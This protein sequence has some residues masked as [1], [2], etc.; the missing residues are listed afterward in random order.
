MDCCRSGS[1]LQLPFQWQGSEKT[2]GKGG[3]SLPSSGWFCAADV[4]LFGGCTNDL[5]VDSRKYSAKTGALTAAFCGILKANPY[6]SYLELMRGLSQQ[7]KRNRADI[8]PQLSSSQTF[9]LT[10]NELFLLDNMGRQNKNKRI[11]PVPTD[12][13]PNPRPL[14]RDVRVHQML[15]E[16]TGSNLDDEIE[17]EIT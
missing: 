12:E 15:G 6:P 2:T 10:E 16:M 13:I 8:R 1:G 4:I 9:D 7:I 5:Q 14:P 3:W 17:L 11:G